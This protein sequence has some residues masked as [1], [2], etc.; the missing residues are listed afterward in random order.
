MLCVADRMSE[1][2]Q[3]S[4]KRAKLAHEEENDDEEESLTDSSDNG[5]SSDS[6]KVNSLSS[7][8]SPSSCSSD[9][10][11]QHQQHLRP[12]PSHSKDDDELDNVSAAFLLAQ[13]RQAEIRA[14]VREARHFGFKEW[15]LRNS[16]LSWSERF[17][18]FDVVIQPDA[19]TEDELHKHLRDALIAKVNLAL[20]PP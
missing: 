1:D 12:P 9:R 6:D 11:L 14:L 2:E 13:Q 7:C 4:R 15:L 8:T 5:E 19:L 18:V 17:E 20:S 10:H 16:H 3:N